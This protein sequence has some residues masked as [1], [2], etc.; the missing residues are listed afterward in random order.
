M[1]A[2]FADLAANL[3]C[4]LRTL[5]LR[6][7]ALDECRAS[8]DQLVLLVVIVLA[9]RLL[10]DLFFNGVDGY[11]N[12]HALSAEI[13]LAAA[14]LLAGFA[15]GRLANEP[16]LLLGYPIVVLA[17]EPF[18][19]A[20]QALLDLTVRTSSLV[21]PGAAW[22]VENGFT[23]WFLGA[24][25]VVLLRLTP[26][27][28]L[29]S[30]AVF[31]A[32][33]T[34]FV[35][36]LWWLPRQE[37]WMARVSDTEQQQATIADEAAF[38]AQPALLERGLDALA[39]ERPGVT[40]IYFVGFAA[41][42]HEDVF[43]KEI[44]VIEQLFRERFDAAGRTIALVNN[45]KTA[46]E[47]PVATVT[48]LTR[49]LRH[50][51]SV[52][53]REEDVLVLYVTSHGTEKHRLAVVNSPLKL[54]D[55][56]PAGLKRALDESG[57][58]WRVLAIS[59][60]YAGGFIA[61]FKDETTLIMTA[62]DAVKP[63]FGCG[64]ESDFTFFGKAVFDEE[65]RRTHSFADAFARARETIARRERE[66]RFEP[67]NPQIHVGRAIAQKLREVESRL[68]QLRADD[69]EQADT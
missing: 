14:L 55:I 57:I 20:L 46:Q 27:H 26:G 22:S 30:I 36:S 24:A 34:V 48:N 25:L 60:C 65:L 21:S 18:F 64:T 3:R 40:D 4:G 68:R 5:L 49:V 38:H 28:H 32:Y 39:P 31:A 58:K 29:R 1:R 7:L 52:M 16:R 45:P 51:G 10:L 63:S 19:L 41:Y 66:H 67:S 13:T 56:T 44:R 2:L 37:L 8:A 50:V 11:F 43:M 47:L 54:D 53:N 15:A 59:A 9:A 17:M 23:A 12:V 42:A 33:C 62:A 35:A 69:D 61:P 6:P